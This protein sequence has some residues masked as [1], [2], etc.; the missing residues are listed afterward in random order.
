MIFPS[1]AEFN[2]GLLDGSLLILRFAH[3]LREMASAGIKP[4]PGSAHSIAQHML[5]RKWSD[6]HY[7]RLWEKLE[8]Q[9]AV[10]VLQ[11]LRAGETL[12]G[13]YD[14]LVQMGER[15]SLERAQR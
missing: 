8:L 13:V 3:E 4:A 10:E 11:K 6:S 12:T 9:M 1:A 2:T 7:R 14:V 15:L 5:S